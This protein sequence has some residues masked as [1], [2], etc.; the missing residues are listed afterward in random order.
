MMENL[1]LKSEITEIFEEMEGALHDVE[2]KNFKSPQKRKKY[3]LRGEMESVTYRFK[4]DKYSVKIIFD[5]NEKSVFGHIFY[6][7]SFPVRLILP[8][9]K[10][11]KCEV[12]DA[13]RFTFPYDGTKFK[14]I[15][16]ALESDGEDEILNIVLEGEE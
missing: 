1:T 3:I 12:D 11:L 7:T 13:G 14:N 15:G 9:G 5:Y 4:L 6:K 10:I 2:W 8:A 16:I